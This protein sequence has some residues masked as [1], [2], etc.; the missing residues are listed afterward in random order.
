MRTSGWNG[1][2][3]CGSGEKYKE[4]CAGRGGA[5]GRREASPGARLHAV[6]ERLLSAVVRYTHQRFGQGWLRQAAEVFFD[7]ID[8]APQSPDMQL[9]MPWAVHHWELKGRPAREWFLEE[10]GAR[11]AEEE[12]AWLLTQRAVILTVWEVREVREEVGLRVKDLLGGGECFAH[13]VLGSRQLRPRQAVLGRLV[14]HQGLAVFCGMDPQPLPPLDADQVVRRVRKMLRMVGTRP[15]PREKL[16]LEKSALGLVHV[17]H[18]AVDW[19]YV[20]TERSP[21]LRNTDGEPLL[22][23]VDHYVFAPGVRHRVLRALA[24]LEGVEVEGGGRMVLHTFMR[25]GNAMHASWENIVVGSAEVELT[26]LLL[27]TNSVERADVLRHR[28]EAA[29]ARLLTHRGRETTAPSELLAE[30]KGRP[31]PPTEPPAPK[32]RMGFSGPRRVLGL[33]E[34]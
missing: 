10:K 3:P 2:C 28:V 13:E 27:K 16:A 30:M 11:L 15:V 25:S 33:E 9:F 29:C 21:E 19:L 1:P 17:W 26:T 5:A 14:E 18:E 7:D 32:E 20:R 31:P 4:C 6:D 12:R 22:F 34:D 8:C 24:R 23:V